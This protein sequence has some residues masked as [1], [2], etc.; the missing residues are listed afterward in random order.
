MADPRQPGASLLAKTLAIVIAATVLLV[1][2]ICVPLRSA[3][4]ERFAAIEH[5]IGLRDLERARNTLADQ[6]SALGAMARDYG[7][8]DETYAY[9]AGKGPANYLDVNYADATLAQNRVGLVVVIAADDKVLWSQG[10]D[11]RDNKRM[12]PPAI[13]ALITS[14]D[15]PL[16]AHKRKEAGITSGLTR[17]GGHTWMVGSH[18]I[19]TSAVQGPARGSMI[20]G[21]R[22]DAAETERLAKQLRLDLSLIAPEDAKAPADVAT[23]VRELGRSDT[24]VRPLNEQ[25]LAGYAQL[26][27]LAGAP[28]G[29]LRITAPRTVYTQGKSDANT[30]ALS[31]ALA[32]L[33]FGALVMLLLHR[34]VIRRIAHLGRDVTAVGIAGDHALR[35]AVNGRDEIATLA[36]DVNGMLGALERLNRELDIERAK[37]ERLLRNI[38]PGPIADRLKEDEG[39]IADSFAAVS[40]LFADIVGFTELSS[41]VEP[42]QLVVMLNGVFSQ[43]DALAERHG[44]EK[45]KTIGDAYMIVA[46]VP[47][48][49]DDH[50]SALATMALDMIDAIEDFNRANSTQLKVRIGLNSGPVVAGVIGTKKF[51]YDLWGD[52]VNIASRME[53]TGIPG[54]VHVTTETHA[55]LEGQFAMEPRGTITVKGK[56][57]MQTWLLAERTRPQ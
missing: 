57:E 2:V 56:G 1:A 55:L 6:I 18:A 38:L 33:V 14:P 12:A 34:V 19:L 51:I 13:S 30:M 23:A 37:G 4:L 35:V 7:V 46:G 31:M 40:V 17:A 52:A 20:L 49:R 44:L 24:L 10:F 45:I 16:L 15:H 8:W 11:L 42:P 36:T 54:R 29:I 28:I 43:F 32:C 26:R 3:M 47:E 5:D 9:A 53:S 21:R 22:L 25:T 50:A 27:D 39:T 48:P 41:R